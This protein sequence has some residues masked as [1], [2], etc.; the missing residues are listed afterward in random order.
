MKQKWS[1]F[2]KHVTLLWHGLD[3]LPSFFPLTQQDALPISIPHTSALRIPSSRTSCRKKKKKSMNS[4]CRTPSNMAYWFHVPLTPKH[5][6]IIEYFKRKYKECPQGW[7][8]A[9]GMSSSGIT[10]QL[11]SGPESDGGSHTLGSLSRWRPAPGCMPQPEVDSYTSFTLKQ[12]KPDKMATALSL[13][14]WLLKGKPRE[15]VKQ[16]HG[17]ISRKWTKFF[18]LGN[19]ICYSRYSQLLEN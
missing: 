14:L 11:I 2:N 19:Q 8:N 6:T 4:P 16:S 12:R 17:L 3:I 10:G 7:N 9:R 15:G 13:E 1:H 18:L 5:I